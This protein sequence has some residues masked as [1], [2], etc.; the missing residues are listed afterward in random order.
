[1]TDAMIMPYSLP[2]SMPEIMPN[3]II[4]GIIDFLSIAVP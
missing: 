4:L 2:L 1:M 3:L